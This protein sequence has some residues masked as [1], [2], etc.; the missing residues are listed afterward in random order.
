MESFDLIKLATLYKSFEYNCRYRLTILKRN[1]Q[2]VLLL[3]V[4]FL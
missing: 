4:Y 2:G 3:G 1:L